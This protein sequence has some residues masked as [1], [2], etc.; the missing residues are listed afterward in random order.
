MSG[1]GKTRRTLKRPQN[2]TNEA[3]SEATIGME[4]HEMARGL[5]NNAIQ[6]RSELLKH[7]IDGGGKDL[8]SSCGYPDAVKAADY[9]NMYAREGVA[10]RVVDVWPEESWSV[11]PI[12]YETEDPEQETE[13]EKAWKELEG[14]FNLLSLLARADTLSGIGQYGVILIGIDDGS[15][16]YEPIES[17]DEKGEGLKGGGVTH[18]LLYGR[19]F[20]ESV[21]E[22]ANIEKDTTNPRFGQPTMYNITFNDGTTSASP[23]YFSSQVHW[24]RIVHLADNREMSDIYGVPRMQKSYNRLL[25]LRKVL[26][27]S[28]EMFWKGG[29]PGLSFEVKDNTDAEI[30][31]TSLR[32]EMQNYM[33]GLQRYIALEGMTAKSLATQVANPRY[34]IESQLNA[35]A[36]AEAVPKRILFGSE[37]GQLAS[38]QD[39]RTWY[40]RLKK[41]QE[42]YLTPLVVR[43]FI[44]RLINIGVL[45]S[46]EEYLVKWPDIATSTDEEKATVAKV[47]AEALSKYVAGDVNQVIPIEEFFSIFGN[48]PA[49]QIKEIMEA[50]D[51]VITDEEGLGAEEGSEGEELDEE[52]KA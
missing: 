48:L 47:W 39:S 7:L 44:N 35:I 25:D 17:M 18:Q 8:N 40:R 6:T 36:I 33:T 50:L 26:G 19:T 32:E 38:S 1:N 37:Q 2:V 5:V 23:S 12:I 11:A 20:E 43:P 30:D 13:F 42:G 4:M 15:N 45:P 29:F 24:H 9:R 22:I 16:L 52:N 21:I 49:D 28:G 41:R 27:G 31:T 34:H 14:K 46:S 51:D 3:K 10:S